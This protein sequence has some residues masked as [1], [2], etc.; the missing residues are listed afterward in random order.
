[1]RLQEIYMQVINNLWLPVIQ[2]GVLNLAEIIIQQNFILKTMI[3]HSISIKKT[4]GKSI[5]I[6]KVWKW[7]KIQLPVNTKGVLN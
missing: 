4:P 3:S 7:L 1:M 2:N 6:K 5:K